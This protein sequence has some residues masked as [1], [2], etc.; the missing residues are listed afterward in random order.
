MAPDHLNQHGALGRLL[1]NKTCLS[2]ALTLLSLLAAGC[3]TP[4]YGSRVE[5]Y[6]QQHRVNAKINKKVEKV[7]DE[8]ADAVDV[9]IGSLPSGL[10]RDKSKLAVEEGR[11]HRILGR[12]STTG[13]NGYNEDRR[14]Y[15]HIGQ[16]GAAVICM[17]FSYLLIGIPACPCMYGNQSN[18]AEDIEL[19]KEALIKA[20][21]RATLAAGGNAVVIDQIGKTAFVD[22]R[23]NV[24]LG[25]QE[26]TSAGGWALV[27]DTQQSRSP[28][29]APPEQE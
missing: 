23:T 11:G 29:E 8:S 10:A 14:G 5:L 24:R 19:R 21:Q 2:G 28:E 17:G 15:C 9:Y 20:L 12:V 26:M 13:L 22:A 1:M 4:R 7:T 3:A 25:T 18:G 16:V 27:L 6:G